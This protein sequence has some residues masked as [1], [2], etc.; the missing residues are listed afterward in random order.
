VQDAK[1][2][3]DLYVK[4][5]PLAKQTNQGQLCENI[6]A[7]FAQN[8]SELAWLLSLEKQFP[9]GWDHSEKQPKALKEIRGA[10]LERRQLSADMRGVLFDQKGNFKADTTLSGRAST[11][12]YPAIKPLFYFK[13]YPEF[14]GYEYGVTSFMRHLGLN[15]APRSELLA[16]YHPIEGLYPVLLSEAVAGKLVYE[17]WDKEDNFSNLDPYYTGL[18][19]ICSMLLN[20]EDSKEDNFILSEDKKQ[21]IPIDNDHAF[22]PGAIEEKRILKVYPELQTKTLAFCLQEMNKPL[23]SALVQQFTSMNV[24][25][26]LETWL[27]ELVKINESY[28]SILPEA[29]LGALW[30]DKGSCLRLPL[31]KEYIQ[32][33]YRKFHLLRILL[34][35]NPE[36]T[37]LA[38]LKR[39]EPYTGKCYEEVANLPSLKARFQAVSGVY[40]K[41]NAQGASMSI[42]S[43]QR[44]M[45][46]MQVPVNAIQGTSIL[47]VLGPVAALAELKAL[48]KNKEANDSRLQA[49]LRGP[50][51]P[52][53]KLNQE[54]EE[55]LIKQWFESKEPYDWI[56][57]HNSQYLKLKH[58]DG[59]NFQ[60]KGHL[61]TALD[62]RG[63]KNLGERGFMALH[64][65]CPNLH[66]LNISVW[67]LPRLGHFQES[68]LLPTLELIEDPIFPCLQ[69]L[70]VQD[71]KA[72]SKIKVHL[73][74]L[75]S[76]ETGGSTN[77]SS[78]SLTAP[79]LRR[80][81]ITGHQIKQRGEMFNLH[82]NSF[83]GLTLQGVDLFSAEE[84]LQVLK[85]QESKKLNLSLKGLNDLELALLVKHPLFKEKCM[86]YEQIDLD[87]NHIGD[88]GAAELAKNLQGT[89]VHTVNLVSNYIGDSGAAEFAKNLKGT[90]V[91]TI[92]LVR[93]EIGDSG[94]AEFAKNLKGTSVHTINL[95]YNKIGDSGAA[96]FAKNLKG[97]SVH[98]IDLSLN[99]IGASGAAELAKNLKGTSVHTIYL[100]ENQIGAS[101]AAEFAKNLQ[102][103]SVHTIYLSLNKIGASGA[104]EF[105]KNLQGTS[106]HTIDLSSN[107]IGDSGAAE[108]AKNLKGTSVHTI[109]LSWNNIGDS[110]AAELAKNLKGTSV[111]T[112]DLSSNRIGDSGAAELAK[113]LQGTSVHTIDLGSNQIGASGAAELAKNLK[114]TSVHTINLRDNQIG[115]SGAAELA[116][117]L[118]GT[119]VHTIYLW[120]NK[121]GDS[122][123]AEFAKNLKG[124]SVHTVNLWGNKI[125]SKTQ[126]LL[127]QQ[128]THIKW[129][130]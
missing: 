13:K 28:Q 54:N 79:N 95:R 119:S 109:D 33:L 96:E 42:A 102:G 126:N 84:V 103:T 92:N 107:R 23:P 53:K 70:I 30:K 105:A 72:L 81:D 27:N 111:H 120:S 52:V 59:F 35:Q 130:F 2:A 40:K 26:F 46:I 58:L 87:R 118:Q 64:K 7:Q 51:E 124:T 77:L 44:L 19:M 76:L 21:L 71:C 83:E 36:I 18:L 16:F 38:L 50:I 43:S 15:T 122:G 110:G 101:G 65:C 116:K 99:K 117:N 114:G 10:S 121:I 112:I 88:S 80:L 115:D 62:L 20:P 66:Y 93:N 90:S 98:T 41:K 125:G 108:L 68:R 8:S 55:I 82:T 17:V 31:T 97:T 106:V 24:D 129:A 32:G 22:L 29:A 94:A 60:N 5:V 4:V 100:S 113:N 25:R 1:A 47:A 49:L 45:E 69:R 34:I 74:A 75:E 48:G 67:P 127:K 3:I 61:L 86:M 12:K 128:Y 9:R 73:P 78:F 89:S 37:P 14:P 56:Q 11:N 91:H 104:A 85:G 123:A 57:L 63:A 6:F 39:L